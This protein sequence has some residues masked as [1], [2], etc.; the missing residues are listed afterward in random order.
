MTVDNNGSASPA[1]QVARWLEQFNEALASGNPLSVAALFHE[2]SY[3]RDLVAFTWNIVTLEGRVAIGDMLRARLAHL[4]PIRFTPDEPVLVQNGAATGFFTF[5]TSIGRGA[6][7][8]RVRDGKCWTLQ[9][10]LMELRGHEERTRE[11]REVGLVHRSIKGRRT[12]RDERLEEER[13]IGIAK[14]PYCLVVGGGQGGLGLGARLK[15]LGVPTLIVDRHPRPGDAWRSRYHS[16]Y[17]H[18]P[19]WY[20]HMPYLP[21]P[22]H[23]PVFMSKDKIG[24]WLE[25][26]ATLMELNFWGSTHVNGASWSEERGEWTVRV[27]REGKSLTLRPKQLVI[28]TGMSGPPYVPTFPGAEQFG[29]IQ[30]HSSEYPGGQG[31]AGKRCVVIG[32]NNSAHDV[33]ADLWEHDAAVTMIQRSP[34]IVVRSETLLEE[35]LYKTYSEQALKA[36]LTTEK[37]D[38]LLQSVPLAVVQ[39]FHIPA[40][41]RI[42]ERD[43]DYYDALKR[44]GFQFNFGPN[45]AGL[46]WTYLGSGSGYYVDVGASDLIAQ[47]EIKVHSGV[48]I[49]AIGTD[50]VMLEDGTRLDADVIVYATGY[51]PMDTVL[52][53]IV[54]PE[55]AAKVGRVWGFGSGT[56][57]DPGPWEGELRNMWKPT[58]QPGLWF[59]GG[60]LQ[61]S[62]G[63]SRYL[64]LQIKARMEDLPVEVYVPDGRVDLR[65]VDASA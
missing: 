16:L 49:R 27:Q 47:G 54:S 59:H 53:K 38:L 40:W 50:H 35:T 1:A 8:V 39:E 30:W 60:S 12:W 5:E 48:Q 58:T 7:V 4:A 29:G 11:R 63:F 41:K 64:A 24:D 31:L 18:D 15:Q 14:Q 17:L 28:A 42:A 37:A 6:G 45:G 23:W 3:W 51:R 20:D 34:T 2:Q 44:A 22:E 10:G 57:K 43:A 61:Q 52:A 21:F 36:G 32:G 65:V 55:V 56:E 25:C 13:S 62:R 9:T 19:V 33:C 26:Y 46:F